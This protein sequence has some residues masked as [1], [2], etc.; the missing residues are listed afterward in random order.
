[1]WQS[2]KHRLKNYNGAIDEFNKAIKLN[3]KFALAYFGRSSA[4]TKLKDYNE[5]IKDNYKANELNHNVL[6]HTI[7]AVSQKRI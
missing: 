3:P 4:K 2:A 7:I 1:M 6:M 5:A